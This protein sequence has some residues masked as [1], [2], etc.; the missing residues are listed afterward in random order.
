MNLRWPL[1]AVV[2][3]TSV[4][5]ADGEARRPAVPAKWCLQ[6]VQDPSGGP[7]L[8]TVNLGFKN[9]SAKRAYPWLVQVNLTPAEK[10]RF[11]HPTRDEAEV[12]NAIEDSI[13]DALLDATAVQ[14]VGR[15][16]SRGSRELVY[17]AADAKKAH[18][19]LNALT[20]K[21]Q[22]RK[23]EYS[24]SK[25][26]GWEHFDDLAGPAPECMEPPAAPPR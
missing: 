23:W 17:F 26:E 4:A 8:I 20:M 2:L 12:L 9:F 18:E 14:F 10:N 16:T 5:W 6:K 7:V 19:V 21:K 11:G 24:I 1:V 15:V 25:D 22:P 13:T 3:L